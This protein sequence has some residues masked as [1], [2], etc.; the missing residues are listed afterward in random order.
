MID[1]S[2]ARWRKSS[3]SHQNGCVEIAQIEGHVVV[4]DSKHKQGPVLVF[5]PSEWRSFLGGARDGQF[6]LLDH[7]HP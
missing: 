4:R 6:D 7:R 5:T 1:L 3:F 2:R